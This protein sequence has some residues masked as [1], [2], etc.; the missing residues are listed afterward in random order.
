MQKLIALL[1]FFGCSYISWGQNIQD[2]HWVK[3]QVED[4]LGQKDSIQLGALMYSN[5]NNTPVTLGMDSLYGEQNIYGQPYQS[6]DIRII[7][8]D[9]LNHHCIQE[10]QYNPTSA[11]ELY[12]PNNLDSKIDF[13]PET[14][15]NAQHNNF[16]IYIHADHY[17]LTITVME[18]HFFYGGVVFIGAALDSNCLPEQQVYVEA[19]NSGD[20]L[21]VL[22]NSYQN[23]ITLGL[24]VLVNTDK[25]TSTNHPIQLFPNPVGQQLFVEGLEELEG[26]LLISNSLGQLV[27]QQSIAKEN[28]QLN[29]AHLNQG[30]YFVNCYDK[31][32]QLLSTQQL[33]K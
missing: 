11:G 24:E 14:N 1:V 23:T 3:L 28:L 31:N 9:S 30:V 21:C 2:F 22:S 5:P 25:L 32:G 7:Q 12:F 4:A 6:L 27:L 15:F 16:E 13:R 26:E 17:P 29:V 18:E 19:G 8:R 10:N 20:T 33:V